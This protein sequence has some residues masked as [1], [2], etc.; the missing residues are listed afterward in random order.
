MKKIMM[1]EEGDIGLKLSLKVFDEMVEK[2]FDGLVSEEYIKVGWRMSCLEEF[3]K[4][5]SESEGSDVVLFEKYM[6]MLMS[7]YD[8]KEN[9]RKKCFVGSDGEYCVRFG[10]V[11]ESENESVFELDNE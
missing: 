10:F 1:I 8:K 11:F 6:N 3:E 5:M 4:L 9:K 7:E 2:E